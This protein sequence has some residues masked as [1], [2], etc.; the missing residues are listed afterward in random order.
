[1]MLS[2]NTIKII[3]LLSI[4]SL[5]NVA[6][7]YDWLQQEE[8]LATHESRLKL[9]QD[10]IAANESLTTDVSDYEYSLGAIKSPEQKRR[11]LR[12][13]VEEQKY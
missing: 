8:D 10:I 11:E 9:W 12:W 2:V 4:S 7:G 3:V 1:M 6:Y 13:Q 5:F